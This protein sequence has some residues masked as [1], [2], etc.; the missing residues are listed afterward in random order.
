MNTEP[1]AT[2]RHWAREIRELV[3][4]P[5]TAIE[6]KNSHRRGLSLFRIILAL[7]VVTFIRHWP[8]APWGKWDFTALAVLVLALPVSDFFALVPVREGLAALVA[9]FSGLVRKRM[10][11]FG[12][13]EDDEEVHL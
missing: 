6:S 4:Y 1:R 10:P 11:R 7:L 9:I 13:S 3:H 8:S 2:R 5:L 12:D